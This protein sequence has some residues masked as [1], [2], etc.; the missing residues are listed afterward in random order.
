MLFKDA[1]EAYNQGMKIRNKLWKDGVYVSIYGTHLAGNSIHVSEFSDEWE[2]LE[3]CDLDYFRELDRCLRECPLFAV[4][5]PDKR[6][7]LLNFIA[8]KIHELS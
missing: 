8:K 6:F 2:L 1:I 4:V 7:K 5:L 3:P